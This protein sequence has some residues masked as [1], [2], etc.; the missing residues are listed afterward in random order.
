ILALGVAG[1]AKVEHQVANRIRR[2]AAVIEH[3]LESWKACYGLVLPEGLQ[4]IGKRLLRN[5]KLAHGFRQRNE[6]GM[7]RMARITSVKFDL[8]LVEQFERS[9]GIAH[10]VAKIVGNAA[11]GVNVEKCCRRCLGKN[12]VATEKF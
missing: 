9:G 3:I 5:G 4:Q 7:A 8:P 12:Q 10:F 2:I 6:Y 1:A 11:I